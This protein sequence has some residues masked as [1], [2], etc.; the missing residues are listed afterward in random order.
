[1]DARKGEMNLISIILV[2]FFLFVCWL[3]YF[4]L[5]RRK[6]LL[7]GL[8]RI[9]QRQSSLIYYNIYSNEGLIHV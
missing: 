4:M 5:V 7:K 8:E 6:I 1:M 9:I 3:I 2:F